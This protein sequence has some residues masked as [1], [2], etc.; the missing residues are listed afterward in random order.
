MEQHPMEAI[1]EGISDSQASSTTN[2]PESST[3]H[4]EHGSEGEVEVSTSKPPSETKANTVSARKAEANRRNAQKSTG[5][6]T[7]EGKAKSAANSYQHGFYA[8]HLFPTEAQKADRPDYL[9][10][11]GGYVEHYQPVGYIENHLVERI[12][13]T[14]LRMARLLRFE[15]EMI[16]TWRLP[17]ASK[18]ADRVLRNEIVLKRE[19][20]ALVKELERVQEKRKAEEAHSEQELET[21]PEKEN[22]AGE[23]QAGT[24]ANSATASS[25]SSDPAT[26]SAGVEGA[27]S[28]ET[29]P[30]PMNGDLG[31]QSSADSSILLALDKTPASS[32]EQS[33]TV[34]LKTMQTSLADL[35]TRTM[36]E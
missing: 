16:T 21:G 31:K 3:I 20:A 35:V 25:F 9:A 2:V 29:N 19:V 24:E 4:P 8:K 11:A 34:G 30:P 28:A 23:E 15:Q 1:G 7:K 36:Q 5:P 18:S 13:V 14:E 17:Y 27:K 22:Q 32:S 33:S 26:T 6:R 12:A 10:V